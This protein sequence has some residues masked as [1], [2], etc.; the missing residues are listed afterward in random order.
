MS[1]KRKR[2]ENIVTALLIAG[3]AIVIGGTI[4]FIVKFSKDGGGIVQLTAGMTEASDWSSDSQTES[5]NTSEN[6][7]LCRLGRLLGQ[8]RPGA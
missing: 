3:M 1:D 7:C 8:E 5:E 2:K 6:R 4:I